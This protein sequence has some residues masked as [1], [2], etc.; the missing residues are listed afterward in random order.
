[1]MDNVEWSSDKAVSVH[2][3]RNKEFLS[4]EI[5]KNLSSS[6]VR[7]FF[8]TKS[9]RKI[10]KKDLRRRHDSEGVNE[11]DNDTF[12]RWGFLRDGTRYGRW[13]RVF[14]IIFY[15]YYFIYTQQHWAILY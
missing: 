7:F 2:T 6:L 3:D 14:S 15:Y 11:I 9:D 8:S 1:M 10:K 5:K 4:R 13:W 12:L